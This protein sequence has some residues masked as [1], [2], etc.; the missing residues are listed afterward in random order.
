MPIYVISTI[1][2]PPEDV[3]QAQ[4]SDVFFYKLTKKN[5]KIKKML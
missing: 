1:F 3:G 5:L 4:L 2:S